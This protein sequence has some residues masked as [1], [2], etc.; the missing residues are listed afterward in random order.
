MSDVAICIDENMPN[1]ILESVDCRL[2]QG[3]SMKGNQALINASHPLS[4]AASQNKSGNLICRN[5]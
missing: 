5:H 2:N 4:T 3:I 1:L